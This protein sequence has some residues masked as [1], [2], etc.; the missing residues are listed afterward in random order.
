MIDSILKEVASGSERKYA[1]IYTTYEL[2]AIGPG[3]QSTG[4]WHTAVDPF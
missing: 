1:S 4:L 2:I 3:H